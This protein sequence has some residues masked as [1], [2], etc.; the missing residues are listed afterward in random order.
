GVWQSAVM[1]LQ[2]RAAFPDERSSRFAFNVVPDDS[3]QVTERCNDRSANINSQK[4]HKSPPC[5]GTANVVM[6]DAGDSPQAG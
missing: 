6:G 3:C 5:H 2:Q 1:R 4:F